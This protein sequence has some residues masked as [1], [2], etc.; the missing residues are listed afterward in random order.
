MHWRS[1]KSVRYLKQRYPKY[2]VYIF[3]LSSR[4][5][6]SLK[7]MYYKIT[8]KIMYKFSIVSEFLQKWNKSTWRII[9]ANMFQTNETFSNWYNSS[10]WIMH[11]RQ[12]L[13]PS[14]THTISLNWILEYILTFNLLPWISSDAISELFQY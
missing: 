6:K 1:M 11:R 4:N 10:T 12:Y 8:Q 3:F 9:L 13:S 14:S 7:K 2:I 5:L